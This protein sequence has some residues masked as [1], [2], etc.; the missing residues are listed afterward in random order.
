MQQWMRF[1]QF[2]N[3]VSVM[4]ILLLLRSG[5]LYLQ[6]MLVIDEPLYVMHKHIMPE[7]SN[8]ILL[9]QFDIL[10]ELFSFYVRM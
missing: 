3:L 9:I 6:F 5:V 4:F 10:W 8:R 2:F 7:M 1:M